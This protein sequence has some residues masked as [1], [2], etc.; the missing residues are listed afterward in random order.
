M[1]HVFQFNWHCPIDHLCPRIPSRVNYILWLRWQIKG[2]IEV[3]LDIGTGATLVYPLIGWR[4]YKWRFIAT[5]I[6]Q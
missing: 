5:E 3:V 1:R 6:D 4:L 2:L